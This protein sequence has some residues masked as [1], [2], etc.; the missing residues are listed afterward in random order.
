MKRIPLLL[1]ALLVAAASGSAIASAHDGSS[2]AQGTGAN[3]RAARATEVVL[4][5]TSLGSILTTSSGFTLYEFTRDHGSANSCVKIRECP[6]VWPALE[7]TGKP[8]AGPGLK[9]SLL[10]SIQ[11]AGGARQVTYAGHPLYLYSADSRDA[12]DYVGASAFGGK[13]YALGASGQAVK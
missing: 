8:T 12:T 10:S 2:T 5:H 13:W 4:R 1:A 7:T 11:I 9:S 6:Q 3:A